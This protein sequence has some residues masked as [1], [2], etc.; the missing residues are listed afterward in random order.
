VIA[1]DEAHLWL[2]DPESLPA[3]DVLRLRGF[4]SEEEVA[5]MER[6]RF[7]RD[8]LLYLAGRG[9]ARA[10]LTRCAGT[11]R[12]APAEWRFEPSLRGR[13][14]IAAPQVAPPLRFNVSHTEGLVAC[15]VTAGADCGVDVESLDRV[16]H[17]D[18]LVEVALAPAE[19]I[20]LAALPPAE[21]PLRFCRTWT[22]KEAYAKA[23]GLGL[24]LLFEDVAFELG[25][26]DAR[27]T[28]G[29]DPALWQFEQ[30]R[31]GPRHVVALALR[32]G[33]A[34]SYRIVVHREL[35]LP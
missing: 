13:P 31:E 11:R 21:Q 3:A 30:W 4:L 19:R 34:R 28:A 2:L 26:D 7:E 5:R 33:D 32:R 22:L 15:A 6:F 9:L 10:A 20:A 18:D 23:C 1:A 12:V 16:R 27:L 29:D 24:S 25:D 35:P 14:E 17:L 8:R